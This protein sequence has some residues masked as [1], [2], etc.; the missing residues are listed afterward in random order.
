MREFCRIL[1]AWREAEEAVRI[2]E[3]H[4]RAGLLSCEL[5]V[6]LEWQRSVQATLEPLVIGY[7][8]DPENLPKELAHLNWT[9]IDLDWP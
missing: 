1:N 2:L 9:S 3:T 8:D 7:Y 4:H 5:L 6:E